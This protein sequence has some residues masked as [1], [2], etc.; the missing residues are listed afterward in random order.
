MS[1][2][3]LLRKLTEKSILKFGQYSD[4]RIYNLLEL[5][6]YS[7]LRW[8][9]F[10][11]SNITFFENILLEIG[12]TEEFFIQ[13]PGVN[14]EFHEKLN[15]IKRENMS[16]RAKKHI[17]KVYKCSMKNKKTNSINLDKKNYSKA[18]L[19]RKNQGH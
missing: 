1:D 18:S 12:I 10:S 17:D 4:A 7:Y 14:L 19:T 8:V 16:L 15:K 2:V 9:Y 11:C 6:K 5:K 3:T 13:K